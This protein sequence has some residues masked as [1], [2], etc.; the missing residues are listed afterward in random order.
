MAASLNVVPANAG[1]H[2]P[3]RS[4]LKKVFGYSA[5][6]IAHG[7]WVPAFAGTTSFYSVDYGLVKV[8]INPVALLA[9]PS[10]ALIS[11]SRVNPGGSAFGSRSV[12]ISVKV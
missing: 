10:S 4:L 8:P 2:N 7:V 11:S 5:K 1:T 3:G 6:T 12:A 9:W